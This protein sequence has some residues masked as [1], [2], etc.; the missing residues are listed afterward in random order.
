MRFLFFAA[1]A[2]PCVLASIPI[3]LDDCGSSTDLVSV[4]TAVANVWPPKQGAE[5]DVSVIG[6]VSSDI[7]GG[8]YHVKV[9]FD[10]IPLIDKTGTLASLK[11]L[12]L[13][14]KSG[15]IN[16][17]KNLTFPK[18]GLS[19]RVD[20]T[21]SATDENGAEILCKS[22][23]NVVIQSRHSHRLPTPPP[24]PPTNDASPPL[25]IL[26]DSF[27]SN[28]S[29]PF[30]DCSTSSNLVKITS[31]SANEWP[32]VQGSDLTL[33]INADV[34]ETI[35]SGKYDAKVKFDGLQIEDQSGDLSSLNLH[36]PINPG[37]I[38]AQ[39]T[40]KIPSVGIHGSVNIVA[41]ATDSSSAQLFCFSV[42]TQI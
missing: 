5:F 12:P 27:L 25:I 32:P 8:N 9:S 10:Y 24:P 6:T 20:I 29:V 40:F 3:P 22:L 15:Q 28:P 37:S 38:V 2:L 16:I 7:T 42:D 18:I 26:D 35:T 34:K 19:G 41:T 11:V 36:Y 39:K 30:T 13:P 23:S 14:I 21:L 31:L 33:F 17:A 4:T 1:L